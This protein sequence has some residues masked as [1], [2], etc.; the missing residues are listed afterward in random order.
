[1]SK[2]ILVNR[3]MT[4]DGTVLQSKS[5]HDFVKY[6]DADGNMYG[7][8][9]G[10]A[11]CLLV[12]NTDKLADMCLYEGDAHEDIRKYFYWGTY[13]KD[14][15]QP[16]KYVI[17]KEMT[18]EHIKAILETQ[19]QIHGTQVGV[20]FETELSYRNKHGIFI[21]DQYAQRI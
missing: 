8:D 14:G 21:D 12:G 17:L 1:M 2:Q 9:G 16:K 4:P 5:V 15:K 13:G 20:L 6:V 7:V 18:N 10:V 11:Y 19:K 3:W